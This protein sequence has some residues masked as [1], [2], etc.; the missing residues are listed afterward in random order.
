MQEIVS[1]ALVTL[2][3]VISPGPNSVLILRSA[4]VNGRSAAFANIGGLLLATCMHAAFSIA[5]LSAIILASST[6]YGLIK[7]AGAVYLIYL[8]VKAL[9]AS[10]MPR[11]KAPAKATPAAPRQQKSVVAALGEGLLTQ[12]LNPKVSMFYLAAFPQFIDLLN[13]HYGYAAMLTGI[14]TFWIAA[15]FSLMTLGLD[16]MAG[17]LGSDLVT[18]WMNRASGIALLGFGAVLAGDPLLRG[19]S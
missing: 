5:G 15:W 11:D 14:H 3:L 2:L 17:A 6:A 4:M 12:L 10:F 1:F 7:I 18:R 16:K 9:R 19:K 8:G 13:P